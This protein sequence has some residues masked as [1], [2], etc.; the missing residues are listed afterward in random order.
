MKPIDFTKRKVDHMRT[1]LQWVGQLLEGEFIEDIKHGYF[2][3]HLNL[4]PS[5]SQK[6]LDNIC[7]HV[8]LYLNLVMGHD[9]MLSNSMGEIVLLS[10]KGGEE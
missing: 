1:T 2:K 10:Y 9:K 3:D 4:Q 7:T 8:N 5:V 6:E